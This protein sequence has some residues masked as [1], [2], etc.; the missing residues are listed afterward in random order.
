M[1]LYLPPFRKVATIAVSTRQSFVSRLIQER[2]FVEA[3]RVVY[4][5]NTQNLLQVAPW[6][7]DAESI[8]NDERPSGINLVAGW[9]G[10]DYLV[11]NGLEGEMI[12]PIGRWFEPG[13]V[14]IEAYNA[15]PTNTHTLN[16][17]FDLVR[18]E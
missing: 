5:P 4:K 15:D 8:A 17:H 16:A 14:C 7:V 1:R 11:G 6:I 2:F 12:I 3:F 10:T 13:R 9:G 18:G